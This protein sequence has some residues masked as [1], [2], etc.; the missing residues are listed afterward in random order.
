MTNESGLLTIAEAAELL[1][2]PVAT[3]R[4][5]RHNGSGPAGFKIGRHVMYRHADVTDWIEA[6]HDRAASPL[7]ERSR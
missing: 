3:L 6:E 7:A 1:R 2:A 5:W 4:W